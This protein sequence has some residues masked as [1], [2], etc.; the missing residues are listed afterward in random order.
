MI[1]LERMTSFGS[2]NLQFFQRTAWMLT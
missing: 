1:T 2:A